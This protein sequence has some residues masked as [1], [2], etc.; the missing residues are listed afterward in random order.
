VAK[1]RFNFEFC[2]DF[3]KNLQ[4]SFKNVFYFKKEPNSFLFFLCLD[5]SVSFQ[6][7]ALNSARIQ[8]SFLSSTSVHFLSVT[9]K[10]MRHDRGQVRDDRGMTGD[11]DDRG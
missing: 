5:R 4:K 2:K 9:R 8:A 1:L 11:R 6:E 10:K 7:F 3:S